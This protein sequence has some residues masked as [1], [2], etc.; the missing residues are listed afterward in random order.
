M[1]GATMSQVKLAIVDDHNLFRKGLIKLINLG[2]K[3]NKY[4]ILFEAES[5]VALQRKLKEGQL[6]DIILLDITMPDMD[7]FEVTQWLRE[8]YPS[9]K[10]LVISMLESEKNIIRMLQ[11]GVKGYLSKNIEVEDMRNALDAI[12]KKG[13]YYS[14][15]VTKAMANSLQAE[16]TSS[17]LVL[18]LNEAKFLQ[19][20][21]TE[22]TYAEIAT[23]MNM[24]PKTIENYREALFQKFNVKSRVGLVLH[25]IKNDLYKP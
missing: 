2:N 7:G 23:K 15:L 13:F 8:N 17:E 24:S 16:H 6:P 21:C 3:E 20:A 19:L 10:V 4:S 14:D 18:S 12:V 22:M 5:G 11:L 25:A 9:I 1:T